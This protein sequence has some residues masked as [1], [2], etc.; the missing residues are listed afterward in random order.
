MTIRTVAVTVMANMVVAHMY[1]RKNSYIHQ[2]GHAFSSS[3]WTWATKCLR[4]SLEG[5]KI[6][7]NFI[8]KSNFMFEYFKNEKWFYLLNFMDLIALYL[9]SYQNWKDLIE[10][11]L[12]VNFKY[13][14]NQINF[15]FSHSKH[16]SM[17]FKHKS[18]FL[19]QFTFYCI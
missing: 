1:H 14:S 17:Y 6:R 3:M 15:I 2:G 11:D 19:N 8:C 5:E 7:I 10:I 13:K 16:Y 18:E 4:V 12:I 9:K